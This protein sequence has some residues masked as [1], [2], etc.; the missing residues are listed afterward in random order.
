MNQ[1]LC[2]PLKVKFH[3]LY[4]QIIVPQ[5]SGFDLHEFLMTK[6]IN[7]QSLLQHRSKHN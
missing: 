3:I 4:N 2:M 7:I 5:K 6:L 1:A